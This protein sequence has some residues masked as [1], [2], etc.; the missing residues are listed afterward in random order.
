MVKVPVTCG[1]G[2]PKSICITTGLLVP[3]FDI[4][5]VMNDRIFLNTTRKLRDGVF[6]C[7]SACDRD[8]TYLPRI[9]IHIDSGVWHGTNM[10]PVRYDT[11]AGSTM[12]PV[13]C[14]SHE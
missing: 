9:I 12:N 2:S 11:N 7:K 6:Q 13:I 5:I 10:N 14:L 4:G 1:T 3:A 8:I